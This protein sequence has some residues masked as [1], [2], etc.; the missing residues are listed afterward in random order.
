[1]A[2]TACYRNFEVPPI[3]QNMSHNLMT[4]YQ[5]R[6]HSITSHQ[7]SQKDYSIPLHV[8]C[9]VE[10][11][12][13]NQAKPPA[14]ARVEPLLMIHPCYF[15]KMESQRRSPFINNMPNQQT[16]HI[17][18]S[19]SLS[20][21]NINTSNAKVFRH[22]S[23]SSLL[24]PNHINHTTPQHHGQ[25]LN[26]ANVQLPSSN[27]ANTL[28]SSKIRTS[29][30]QINLKQQIDEYVQRQIVQMST[31]Q[32]SIAY[33]IT[34][35]HNISQINSQSTS[36][37]SSNG[38]YL[39]QQSQRSTSTWDPY[40]IGGQ[41]Q[42]IV[43]G[44]NSKEASHISNTSIIEGGGLLSTGQWG[45]NIEK[46]SSMA[47]IPRDYQSGPEC[48]P[49]VIK[50]NTVKQVQHINIYRNSV[51]KRD[52]MLSGV[53]SGESTSTEISPTDVMW[54]TNKPRKFLSKTDTSVNKIM[55]NNKTSSST[56]NTCS[57]I[58]SNQIYNIHRSSTTNQDQR[59]ILSGK[60]KQYLRSQRLHPYS[61]LPDALTAVTSESAFPQ[62]NSTPSMFQQISCFNV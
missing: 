16:S 57:S 18:S 5:A 44:H 49:I 35:S 34:N 15:R 29:Q 1:M 43:E 56:K 26:T 8:D 21:N 14:G 53:Y 3:S 60:Y 36:R 59:N 50:P 22:Q 39:G 28:S 4:S 19:G 41:H 62:I 24:R 27:T 54:K 13:P 10:Y 33:S 45:E 7:H 52:A 48:I 31:P 38:H 20:S 37:A 12:L 51:G 55:S 17:N 23:S 42:K 47:A 9:S 30:Q 58:Q 40:N 2:M 11:E 46:T 61:L 32:T 25:I 6:H